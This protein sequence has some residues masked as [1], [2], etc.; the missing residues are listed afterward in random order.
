MAWEILEP[1]VSHLITEDDEPV[2]SFYQD[3]Q[4]R[5]LVDALNTSWPEGRPFISAVDVAIFATTKE[6]GIVPDVMLSTGVSYPADIMEKNRRSYFM[7]LF[8]KPPEVVVEIVSNRLGGEDTS[9][10]ESYARIK[11]P[12][13]VVYDPHKLLSQRCLRVYQL[14][15]ASYVEKVDGWF[16]EI[17]LGVTLWTGSYETMSATWLRWCRQDGQLLETGPEKAQSQNSL[18]DAEGARADAERARADAERARA[19]EEQR[20]RLALEEK[21][22]SLGVEPD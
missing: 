7:W 19:D 5:I 4:Q 22:R 15:G 6:P 16:P 8:G 10:L 1:D 11:V 3:I 14:S 20:K 13:Y 18:A 12:Y 9:K 17:K 21:L 2:E